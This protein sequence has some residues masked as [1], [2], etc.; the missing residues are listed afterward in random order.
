[1]KKSWCRRFAL[2]SDTKSLLAAL[3]LLAGLFT[4]AVILPLYLATAMD[5]PSTTVVSSED[6]GRLRSARFIDRFLQRE[7]EIE[8]DKGVFL[9]CGVFVALKGHPM[10][11]EQREDGGR[12]L[13]DSVQKIC[14]RLVQQ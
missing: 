8:T 12:V 1:M 5:S 11:L 2:S 6:I 4:I 3:L 9:V 7:T 13:C 10:V 14:A